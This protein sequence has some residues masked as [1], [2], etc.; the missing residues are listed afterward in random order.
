MVQ[1]AQNRRRH[2][3]RVSGEAVTGGHDVVVVGRRIGNARSQA[4]VWATPIIAGHPFGK[5]PSEMVFV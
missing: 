4:G 3:L 1:P 5:D 2:H